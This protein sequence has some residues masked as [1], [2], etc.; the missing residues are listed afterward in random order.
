MPSAIGNDRWGF[1]RHLGLRT[2][3]C[4]PRSRACHRKLRVNHNFLWYYIRDIGRLFGCC[5][6]PQ[7]H[8]GF[9]AQHINGDQLAIGLE[10]PEG[11]AVAG[12][13]SLNV[14]AHLVD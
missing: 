3:G 12:I 13:G 6:Q 8:A 11:P 1:R 10:V 14:S 2:I 9:L 7:L 5:L 4:R